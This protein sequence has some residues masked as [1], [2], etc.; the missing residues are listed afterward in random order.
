M[1]PDT[2]YGADGGD[3]FFVKHPLL[4]GGITTILLLVIPALWLYNEIRPT[5]YSEGQKIESPPQEQDD[6]R[7]I[8]TMVEALPP[9]ATTTS[10]ILKKMIEAL[11]PPSRTTQQQATQTTTTSPPQTLT[12]DQQKLL[13]LLPPPMSSQ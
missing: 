11:P 10:P 2:N 12:A 4:L 6:A 9:P 8:E 1:P 13:Q 5:P 7:S 3:S